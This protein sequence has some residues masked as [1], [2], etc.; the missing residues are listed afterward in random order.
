MD[1]FEI[2]LI[3]TTYVIEPQEIGTFRGMDGGEKVV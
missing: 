2:R 3:E 1:S